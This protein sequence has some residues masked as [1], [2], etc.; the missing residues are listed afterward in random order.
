MIE[1]RR[2]GKKCGKDIDERVNEA[3][4]MISRLREYSSGKI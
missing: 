1:T 2:R 4:P 3:R